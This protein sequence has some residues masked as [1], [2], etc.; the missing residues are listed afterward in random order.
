M[1]YRNQIV[2]KYVKIGEL[3]AQEPR[4][5]GSMTAV[6]VL[7]DDGAGGPVHSLSQSMYSEKNEIGAEGFEAINYHGVPIAHEYIDNGIGAV[8]YFSHLYNG[9]VRATFEPDA[10]ASRRSR[11]ACLIMGYWCWDNYRE[12]PMDLVPYLQRKLRRAWLIP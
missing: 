9:G 7:E 2:D 1:R 8:M 3:I 12:Y 5:S 11:H 6:T 10:Y 4:R